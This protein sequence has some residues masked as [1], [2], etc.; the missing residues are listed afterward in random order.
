MHMGVGQSLEQSTVAHSYKLM[1]AHQNQKASET[2]N[3]NK[4]KN[5]N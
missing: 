1:V 3:I 2:D 4:H 5:K